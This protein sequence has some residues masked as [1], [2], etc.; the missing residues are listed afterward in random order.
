M[1][2]LEGFSDWTLA[3]LPR[4]FLYPGGVWM[5]AAVLGLRFASGGLA[6]IKPSA[7][8]SDLSGVSLLAVAVAW[9]GLSLVPLPDASPLSAPLVM[10]AWV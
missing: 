2:G 7:L 10:R 9:A 4:L 8:V 1:N 3:L 5:L 6:A